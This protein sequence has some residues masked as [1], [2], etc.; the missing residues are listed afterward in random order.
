MLS[1][2]R[3]KGKLQ[4]LLPEFD[5]FERPTRKERQAGEGILVAV[6]R[7]TAYSAQLLSSD[8]SSVWVKVQHVSHDQ[9]VLFVS[10]VYL[11]PQG[12][13]KLQQL[14]LQDRL[15]GLA[16]TAAAAAEIGDV[17]LG[18]DFNARVG[19]IPDGAALL[20]T[21]LPAVRGMSDDNSNSHGAAMIRF[22]EQSGLVLCTGRIPGDQ[23]ALPT[24]K[25]RSNTQA[26]RIDHLLVSPQAAGKLHLC[27]VNQQQQGSDHWPI[28]AALQLPFNFV[29]VPRAAASGVQLQRA[30]WN[31][32][33]QQDYAATLQKDLRL[34]TVI[35]QAKNSDLSAAAASFDEILRDS[36][37]AAAMPLR[38]AGSGR[39]R[40]QPLFFDA[41]IQQLK[42]HIRQLQRSGGHAQQVRQLRK[43]YRQA[44]RKKLRQMAYRDCEIKT[45]QLQQDPHKLFAALRGQGKRLPKHLEDTEQWE[46]YFVQLAADSSA[47][48]AQPQ[49]ET[50]AAGFIPNETSENMQQRRNDAAILNKPFTTEEIE[51]GVGRLNNNRAPGISGQPAEMLR[52]AV[53]H[54]EDGTQDRVLLPA[55]TAMLN[56]ALEL[57]KL[58]DSWNVS[59]VS[60]IYKRGDPDSTA[61]Y[62][63]IAVGEPI[64]RLLAVIVNRRLL[65]FTESHG[66]RSPIQAGFRPGLACAHQLFGLQHFID[67]QVQ[68]HKARLFCCFVDLKGAY[69]NVPHSQLWRTLSRLGMHGNMLQLIQGMYANS[70]LAAS[71]AGRRGGLHKTEIGVKQGCPLSPTLFGL[72]MD[73]LHSHLRHCA[74]ADGPLLSTGQ[75]VPALM[76]ADDIVLMATTAAGLQRLITAMHRLCSCK[77]MTISAEK[78]AVVVFRGVR[79]NKPDSSSWL[80]GGSLLQQRDAYKYLGLVFSSVRGIAASMSEVQ[81]RQNAAW[82]LLMQRYAQLTQHFSIELMLGLYQT[83]VPPTACYASE[84][85]GLRHMVQMCDK[86]R[87][88]IHQRH[89]RIL[90][91]ICG[92]RQS[93]PSQMVLQELEVHPLEQLWRQQGLRFWNSL[94]KLPEDNV[95]KIIAKDDLAAANQQCGMRNWA[96]GLIAAV[97]PYGLQLTDAVDNLQAVDQQTFLDSHTATAAQTRSNLAEQN[98]RSYQSEG[99]KECT[100]QAWFG[101]PFWATGPHF[102]QLSL[103]APQRR[104]ILRLRLGSHELPVET[105]R[106]EV[107]PLARHQRMCLACDANVVGDEQH[108]LMECAATADVRSQFADLFV[109]PQLAMHQLMWH[110]DR[111]RVADFM[112]RCMS[113]AAL[114]TSAH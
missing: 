21:S 50:D 26:T 52:Y 3:T 18:G 6:K 1:E 65:D 35:T 106:Q 98:P 109:Q 60:P 100:Y 103:S 9:R 13:R 33:Q 67:Q 41:Q 95:Y 101:R 51:D 36:A 20:Q 31:P 56:A 81:R 8:E 16:T 84:V 105:G 37:T 112:L 99:I 19:S 46:E 43:R 73:S 2:T 27:A 80:C 32:A 28:E 93:V 66:L 40:K 77:M 45:Q 94:V 68:Q 74:P 92:V 10:A 4:Q 15:D 71:I 114:I 89:V 90:R 12:S 91:Q 5:V 113:V 48:T 24:F 54:R 23:E 7:H 30:H 79:D 75:R 44:V 104:A 39:S 53:L 34:A 29:T 22:C 42:I 97:R 107:P 49:I 87:R 17:V 62:R 38:N 108:L 61:N 57:G 58:P 47:G 72:Y 64:M 88:G 70:T 76:Y 83:I 11:P 110:H 96:A 55:L 78:T 85:W 25:A 86:F 59:L 102:W 111:N 14:S 63:P 69:D 82:G